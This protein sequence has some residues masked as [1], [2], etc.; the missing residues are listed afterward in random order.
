MRKLFFIFLMMFCWA[1]KAL[2][3]PAL[4]GR[5]VDEANLLT[6]SQKEE[7]E[8][9]LEQAEPHQV[10]AVSLRSLDGKEIEEY[11]YQLGRHWGIGRK[12]IN[13]GVLVLIAPNQKQLRIEVGYGLEGTL[14]DALSS[15]IVNRIMLPLARQGKYAEALIEGSQAVLD[16]LQGK[17]N[18]KELPTNDP[19]KSISFSYIFLGLILVWIIRFTV[20]NYVYTRLKK[21]DKKIET[22]NFTIEEERQ[23]RKNKGKYILSIIPFI[24]FYS[25]FFSVGVGIILYG[26]SGFFLFGVIWLLFSFFHSFAFIPIS[27]ASQLKK[28]SN[29]TDKEYKKFKRTYHGGGGHGGGS[30]YGSG[31]SHSSGGSSFSGGGGSFGGGGSSGRW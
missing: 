1:G 26:N 7:L 31:S 19:I 21:S 5:V 17:N 24:A 2:C 25:I 9:L 12:D 3:F 11:G 14:T 6:Y 28:K 10:V 15:R 29:F 8:Q 18:L 4:T 23:I 20:P 22:T 13:D 30:S 27:F 16:V